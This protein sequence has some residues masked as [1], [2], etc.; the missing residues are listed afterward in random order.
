MAVDVD[1]GSP[2]SGVGGQTPPLDTATPPPA[3]RRWSATRIGAALAALAVLG[4]VLVFTGGSDETPAG[5]AE[6][7]AAPDPAQG[8]GAPPP[9]LSG[10]LQEGFVVFTDP[11]TGISLQHPESWVPLRRPQGSMRLVL[12]AGGDSSLMIRVEPIETVIDTAEELTDVQAVTDRI[13]GAEPIQVVQRQALEVNGMPG[14][15]YLGRFTDEASGTQVVNAHY[16][17]F[18]GK[19]MHVVLFQVAPED[20]FDELAPVF[21][22][23]LA[24]FQGAPVEDTPAEPT[25]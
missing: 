12:S 25:G 14:I 5:D 23:V 17:L 6:Q 9:A 16:F 7:P 15:F 20:D 24:S 22:R 1:K 13:A 10:E 18:K 2:P 19:T 3:R 21:D 4:A 8:D 11:E